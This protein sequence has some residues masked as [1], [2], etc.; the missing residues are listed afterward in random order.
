M[1]PEDFEKKMDELKIPSAGSVKPP[2]EIKLAIVNAQR[3]AAI[4]VWFVIVPYFFFACMV[5]KYELQINLG[6]LDLFA[7]TI[8]TIDNNPALWWLQ[9]VFLIG[10]P[11]VGIVLNILSITHFKW[12]TFTSSIT[13]TL[14]LRWY[15]LIVLFSS[16]LILCVFLLYLI[17]GNFQA[18]PGH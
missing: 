6:L 4:G 15:N 2:L 13:V 14:K 16:G 10:L 12:D 7:E 5:M 8:Q 18:R 11:I 9:P 3:S 1:E 17:G